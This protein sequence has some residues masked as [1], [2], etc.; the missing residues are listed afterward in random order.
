MNLD[1]HIPAALRQASSVLQRTNPDYHAVPFYSE[2][3]RRQFPDDADL[4]AV[5]DRYP[6]KIT[7]KQIADFA[8]AAHSRDSHCRTLFKT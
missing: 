5:L 1:R 7:R 8:Y 2:T 3:W 4:E 6:S